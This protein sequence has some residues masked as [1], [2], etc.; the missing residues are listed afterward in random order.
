MISLTAETE[1]TR[2]VKPLITKISHLILDFLRPLPLYFSA[3][4]PV[5]GTGFFRV[6]FRLKCW[7]LSEH[8]LSIERQE[9]Y[10]HAHVG[11]EPEAVY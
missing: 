10:P 7:R 1:S 9:N 5:Y 8:K 3:L 2:L 11:L 4:L 6:V